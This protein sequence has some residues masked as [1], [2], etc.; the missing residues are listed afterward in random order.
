MSHTLNDH[1]RALCVAALSQAYKDLIEELEASIRMKR[2]VD[3][4]LISRTAN[5]MRDLIDKLLHQQSQKDA[6]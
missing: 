2:E 1:E 5:E 4:A 3:T 6:G